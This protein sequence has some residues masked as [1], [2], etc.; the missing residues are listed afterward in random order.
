MSAHWS[1]R[2]SIVPAVYVIVER[3][4]K[5][6][7][8]RRANTSYKNGFYTTPCGHMD[9]DESPSAA[10]AREA[11]EEAG[12]HIKSEDLELVHCMMYKAEEGSHERVSL[13]FKPVRF[14]GEAQNME[15]DKCD[16][17]IWVDKDALPDNLVWE[18]RYALDH[19]EEGR[20][21]S[22]HNYS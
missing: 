18:L 4:G 7:L 10:A 21:Y 11:R 12:L 20:F 6:L 2:F 17:L 16:E 15:P 5:L 14:T 19:I 13:F 3:D 22:E 1:E 9:G 8:L